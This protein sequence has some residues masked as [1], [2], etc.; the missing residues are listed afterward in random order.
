MRYRLLTLGILLAVAVP[1][2]LVAVWCIVWT[3][4]VTKISL[5]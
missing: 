1:S 4:L 5:P 2:V 3:I